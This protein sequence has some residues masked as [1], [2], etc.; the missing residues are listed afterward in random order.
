MESAH[1]RQVV[2]E[3]ARRQHGIVS[4]AQLEERGVSA[5]GVWAWV[6]VGYL[7]RVQQGVYAVGHSLLSSKGRLLAAVLACGPDAV[8]S[9]RSAAA[10]WGLRADARAKIDVTA[11]NRR[12]RAPSGIDA[13]R[14]GSLHPKDRTSVDSIPCT[15]FGRT[16]LDLAGVVEPR[17]LRNAITRAEVLRIFDL[18]EVQEVIARNRGRRGVARLRRALANADSRDER[19]KGEFERRFL[20]ICRRAGLPLPEVNAPLEIGGEQVEADF[21][22]RQVRLIVETDDRYSHATLTAFEKDRRRDQRLKLADW[23]VIR[24]TWRQMTNEPDQLVH[25]IRALLERGKE[26]ADRPPRRR[27]ENL[28]IRDGIGPSAGS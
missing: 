2:A 6:E 11:P 20:A 22:W 16:L 4:L 26:R 7:H 25:T 9:H 18:L 15:S 27:A 13:H 8:L 12:G 1:R 17:E 28:Q 10:L 3:L 19:A 14:N 5:S 21:L 23:D 24:C